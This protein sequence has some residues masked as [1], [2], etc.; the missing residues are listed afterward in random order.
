MNAYIDVYKYIHTYVYI[1]NIYGS[2]VR[3]C[4]HTRGSAVAATKRPD[5]EIPDRLRLRAAPVPE[6]W[7]VSST[8]VG[9]TQLCDFWIQLGF[10]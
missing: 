4:C 5:V 10:R 6:Q 7:E 3:S 8:S 1:M 9:G 2:G